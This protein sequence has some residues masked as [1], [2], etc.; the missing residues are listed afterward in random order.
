M[1]ITVKIMVVGLVLVGSGCGSGGAAGPDLGSV[2]PCELLTQ[3]ELAEVE[4]G[5][6]RPADAGPLRSCSW[7]SES[8]AGGFAPPVIL[9]IMP[10]VGL[11][12][13]RGATGGATEDGEI[14]GRPA[15]STGEPVC[16]VYVDLGTGVLGTAGGT[17]CDTAR[18]M[19]ELAVANLLA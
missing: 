7:S 14:G 4:L 18:R 17:D 16:S 3:A 12:E 13:V 6:G 11:D 10:E 8:G 15:V 2:A 19:T 5:V 1:R 9:S